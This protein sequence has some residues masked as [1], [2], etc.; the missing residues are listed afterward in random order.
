MRE[1]KDMFKKRKMRSLNNTIMLIPTV[2]DP[3]R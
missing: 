3:I 2:I 1:L